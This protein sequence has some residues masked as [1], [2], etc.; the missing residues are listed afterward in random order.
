MSDVDAGGVAPGA[1]LPTSDLTEAGTA[2]LGESTLN[3]SSNAAVSQSSTDA[4]PSALAS[5]NEPIQPSA[6]PSSGTP[7]PVSIPI[8]GDAGNGVAAVDAG[9]RVDGAAPVAGGDIP[10]VDTG[11]SVNV[12]SSPVVTPSP[13]PSIDSVA[14]VAAAGTPVTGAAAGDAHA[15]LVAAMTPAYAS[16]ARFLDAKAASHPAN[17][18]ADKIAEHVAGLEGSADSLLVKIATEVK[19]LVAQIKATL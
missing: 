18:L 4:L 16:L 12:G 15:Q 9:A 7:Q 1:A 3:G 11:A 13:S 5:T 17:G 2:A 10:N 19:K 6:V 8:A 14:I